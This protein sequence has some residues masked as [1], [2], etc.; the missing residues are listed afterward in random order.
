[1]TRRRA[2]Q[3]PRS[4]TVDKVFE[5]FVT[6]LRADPLIGEAAADRMQAAL[7]PGKTISAPNL[8][9]ALFPA[10]ETATK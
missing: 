4:P 6:E 7:A 8:E 10:E 5:A 3:K 1:M 2:T 9:K